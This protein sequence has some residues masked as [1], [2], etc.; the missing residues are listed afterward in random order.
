MLASVIEGAMPSL[1][2]RNVD[3]DVVRRLKERAK[4]HG[5]S[6]E[7]E[8][9]RILE[10]VLAPRWTTRDLVEALQSCSWIGELDAERLRDRDPPRE[11]AF[12][13]ER[14]TTVR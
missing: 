4:Q 8:H 3:D 7:A 11:F 13:P 10:A 14:G 2:V 6:V 5:R 9:R 12:D 1:L